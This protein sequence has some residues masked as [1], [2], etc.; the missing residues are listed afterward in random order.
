MQLEMQS[1]LRERDAEDTGSHHWAVWKWPVYSV[2]GC[3]AIWISPCGVSYVCVNLLFICTIGFVL[4]SPKMCIICIN[5][6]LTFRARN[7]VHLHFVSP[8]RWVKAVLLFHSWLKNYK[9]FWERKKERKKKIFVSLPFLCF[10][11]VC[12]CE[13]HLAGR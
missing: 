8:F 9:T 2:H 13:K 1:L 11:V 4:Y 6:Q 7:Y 12:K 5:M 10:G 3:C